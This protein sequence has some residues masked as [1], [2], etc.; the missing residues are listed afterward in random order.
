VRPFAR[1]AKYVALDVNTS[2]LSA[3]CGDC[4]GGDATK[5]PIRTGSI[6][7]VVA[8]NV[9]GDVGLG[10]DFEQAVGMDSRTYSDTVSDLIVRG[11]RSELE[12]L[13]AR[14]RAMTDAVDA[15]KQLLLVEAARVL[16]RG[17]D[18]VIVETLT[19][20]FAREWLERVCGERAKIDALLHLGAGAVRFRCR[21]V[22]NHN[23]R[24]R[25]CHSSELEEPSLAVWVLTPERDSNSG[26]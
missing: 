6:D 22:P 7:H 21:A 5:L 2:L 15:T 24:R 19:P 18:V 9:F 23:R 26:N 1:H 3:V 13:R 14:V 11:A 8:C 16:R 10:Y 12:R 4:V 20:R 25:Y 17:G